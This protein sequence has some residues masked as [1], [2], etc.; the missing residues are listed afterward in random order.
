MHALVIL[1]AL[2]AAPQPQNGELTHGLM[3][4]L[5]LR[6]RLPPGD[7][8][9]RE[10]FSDR[11]RQAALRALP[12][13]KL[14]TRENME[15]IAK[16]LGVDLADCEGECEV[17]T[18]RRLGADTVVS[19]EISRVGSLYKVTLRL[20][21]TREARLLSV[22][23]AGGHSVEDLDRDLDQATTELLA[24]LTGGARVARVEPEP[25]P[26][27]PV[28]YWPWMWTRDRIQVS[29]GW[30][31]SPGLGNGPHLMLRVFGLE[32]HYFTYRTGDNFVNVPDPGQHWTW[33]GFAFGVSPISLATNR[34][35]PGSFGFQWFEPYAL[36][37][38][39]SVAI[40]GVPSF[41]QSAVQVGNRFALDIP[42]G[43]GVRGRL[44]LDVGGDF[45]TSDGG[46]TLTSGSTHLSGVVWAAVGYG[47]R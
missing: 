11:V 20:H 17:V 7:N 46:Y 45:I 5:E 12:D 37:R 1:A 27:G 23:Q 32:A 9:D 4:V 36:Y 43:A 10:Y 30:T 21:A 8:I 35:D 47:S 34:D 3:A 6:N 16:S 28:P 2:L 26:S 22:G 15:V 42:F 24:P 40:T 18:G 19:G 14:M 33:T 25:A 13:L 39:G 38:T 41:T 29:G 44:G 31:G